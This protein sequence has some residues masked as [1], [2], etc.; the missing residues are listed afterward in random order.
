MVVHFSTTIH[1][2]EPGAVELNKPEGR[3]RVPCDQV[4]LKLG[5]TPPR[6]ALESFGIAFAGSGRDARP[7]LSQRYESS[8]PGLFLVGAVTGRDLIKLGINQGHEVVEHVL[9]RAVEPADEEVLKRRLPF[10]AA[11]CGSASAICATR[12]RCSRS[13]TRSCCA[14]CCSPPRSASTATAR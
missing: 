11:R 12:S 1:H 14:R 10:W 6:A 4:I 2:V 8:V 3:V 13:P 9:G 7:V 5:A